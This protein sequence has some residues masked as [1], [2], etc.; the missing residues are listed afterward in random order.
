MA[1]PYVACEEFVCHVSAFFPLSQ[2]T[3]LVFAG[4]FVFLGGFLRRVL[5]RPGAGGRLASR[6]GVRE[7]NP[8]VVSLSG[9]PFLW[10]EGYGVSKWPEAMGIPP[11]PPSRAKGG[12]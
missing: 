11:I 10:D 12:F 7:G 3:A 5:A 6:S 9:S 1:L 4:I 2:A 8:E